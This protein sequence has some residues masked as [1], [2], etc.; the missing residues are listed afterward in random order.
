M[1]N[2]WQHQQHYGRWYDDQQAVE[3]EEQRLR[4]AAKRKSPQARREAEMSA[5]A[6]QLL[7]M[8]EENR[9]QREL[10]FAPLLQQRTG[11]AAP[12]KRGEPQL[13]PPPKLSPKSLGKR[14][15]KP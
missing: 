15:D 6:K 2:P 4:E 1:A 7:R 5:A 12:A 3:L 11:F 9:R 13:P 14:F 8:A 10:K